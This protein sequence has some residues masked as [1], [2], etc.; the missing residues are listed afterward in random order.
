[1]SGISYDLVVNHDLELLPLIT[2]EEFSPVS[3]RSGAVHVD[4]HEHHSFSGK[5]S[6][7]LSSMW[8]L[9]GKRLAAYHDWLLANLSSRKIDLTTVVNQ[10]IGDWYVA[11]GFLL[12]YVPITNAAPYS[13]LPFAPRNESS[14]KFIH[15]GKFSKRRGLENLVIASLDF[16]VGDTLHFMLTGDSK[17]IFEFRKWA[18]AINPSILFHNPVLMGEVTKALS[19]FDAELIYF[20]PTS[21]NMLF[22]LPNKFFEALQGNLAIISGPSPELVRYADEFG[23]GKYCL[24]WDVKEFTSLVRNMDRNKVELLRNKAHKAA[25]TLNANWEA[26][27]LIREWEKQLTSGEKAKTTL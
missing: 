22:T 5:E 18:Q 2:R 6:G 8:R 17:D 25:E 14:L 15:H 19:E 1:M 26:E 20:E 23:F 10:S 7:P 4:L 12:Q 3:V 21:K 16:R 9:F 24:T 13:N 27:K 11:N